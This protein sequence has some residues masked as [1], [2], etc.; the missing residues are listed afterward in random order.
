MKITSNLY[1]C[2]VV[3]IFSCKKSE[4]ENTKNEILKTENTISEK[5]SKINVAN[6][7]Q[8]NDFLNNVANP[9]SYNSE[10][11]LK[12]IRIKKS[13]SNGLHF[14]TIVNEFPENWVKKEE[15]ENLIGLIDSKEN[16]KCLVNPLS[17]KIPI[18]EKSTIGG[19]AIM[20]IKSFKNKTKIDIGLTLCP[21]TAPNEII[22]I[23]NWWKEYNQK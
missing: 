11:L 16:C 6:F 15:I 18:N 20:L 17:S 9:K 22:E 8:T 12:K 2:L 7:K 13:E 14:F 23:K 21:T 3:L 5:N 19:Y 1:L 4:T 10:S